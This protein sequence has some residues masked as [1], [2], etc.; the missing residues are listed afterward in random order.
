MC[1]LEKTIF[2]G[3]GGGGGVKLADVG[4]GKQNVEEKKEVTVRVKRTK[5]EKKKI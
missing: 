4:L 3:V 1:L 2:S 5:K